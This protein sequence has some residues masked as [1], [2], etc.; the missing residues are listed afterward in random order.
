MQFNE[1]AL[2]VSKD[3]INVCHLLIFFR[4]ERSGQRGLE[5]IFVVV[6]KTLILAFVEVIIQS[7]IHLIGI[8]CTFFLNFSPLCVHPTYISLVSEDRRYLTLLP[9][10]DPFVI[11]DIPSYMYMQ[12]VSKKN[13]VLIVI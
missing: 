11:F 5:L 12:S 8:Y 4:M 9:R 3:K 6:E 10:F 2:F 13:C 7:L 1:A